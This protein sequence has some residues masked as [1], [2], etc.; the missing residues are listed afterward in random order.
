[1]IKKILKNEITTTFLIVLTAI[2]TV[3]SLANHPTGVQLESSLRRISQ[4]NIIYI[5]LT[6]I[7]FKLYYSFFLKEKPKFHFSFLLLSCLFAFFMVFGY[8]FNETDSWELVLESNFAFLWSTIIGI[9]YSILFYFGIHKVYYYAKKLASKKEKKSNKLFQFLFEEHPY[10]S[11]MIILLICWMPYLIIHFP[12]TASSD[13]I[14]QIKQ[15]YNINTWTSKRVILVDPN[16]YLNNHHPVF[17]TM[18]LGFFVHIGYWLGNVNIGYFS[19][20]L[21]QSILLAAI[22]AYTI[23]F[24]KKL[25]TPYCVRFFFLLCYAFLP[26]F[27]YYAIVAVKDVPFTIAMILANLLIL[28]YVIDPDS[29]MKQRKNLINLFLSLLLLALFRNNGVYLL[30]ILLPFILFVSKKYRKQIF[31]IVLLP[32]IIYMS[33]SKLLLPQLGISSG[34]IREVLSIPFQQ[35]ARYVKNYDAEIPKEEKEIIDKLLVYDTISERYKPRSSDPVKRNFNKMATKDDLNNYF[36]VWFKQ[37]QRH[38]KVYVSA[39]MNN[40]FGYFYPNYRGKLL[41]YHQLHPDAKQ[42]EL[43]H[44]N[45]IKLFKPTRSFMKEANYALAN[46]PLL[47]MF[48]SIGFYTWI[49]L[50]TL[51]FLIIKKQY[52]FIV[53][54]ILLLGNLLVNCAAPLNAHVRY[55]IPII[56]NIPIV[57]VICLYVLRR[58][59]EK[60]N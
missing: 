38:P 7:F 40:Y 18:F 50:I 57:I 20:I 59:N 32:I 34:S 6:P 23:Y 25:Q 36:H 56:F 53:P 22:L 3:F 11:I 39:T 4:Y 48:Y 47:G 26:I 30:I 21:F 13:T 1:M 49:I 10:L 33:Y 43:F 12:G 52:K 15:F 27:P 9:G 8:S 17:H 60:I 45:N 29:F 14:D 16:I 58:N 19:F 41:I 46:S 51:T 55:S 28:D 5:I 42:I 2:L 24:M 35:T 31:I 54:F 37:L 44:L